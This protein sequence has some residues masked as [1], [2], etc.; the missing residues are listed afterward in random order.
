MPEPLKP[1]IITPS[2]SRR[3]GPT[4]SGLSSMTKLSS[5]LTTRKYKRKPLGEKKRILSIESKSI[6]MPTCSS[7]RKKKFQKPAPSLRF[8]QQKFKLKTNKCNH[9]KSN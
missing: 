5:K 2:S 8:N 1:A 6:R 3:K 9:S 4:V 7:T